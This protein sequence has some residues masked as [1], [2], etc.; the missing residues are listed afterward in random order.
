M[1]EIA[2]RRLVRAGWTMPAWRSAAGVWTRREAVLVAVE[3]DGA[4]G[5]GEAAPLPGM[6]REDVHACTR[7]IASAPT[8][9]PDELDRL[10]AVLDDAC[11][12]A[13]AWALF[14]AVLDARARA[15]GVSLASLLGRPAPRLAVAAVVDGTAA[16]L[17]ATTRGVRTLKLK[18]APTSG[19]VRATAEAVATIREAVGPGAAIRVD[20]NRSFA[21]AEVPALLEALTPLAIELV[22]EPALGLAPAL[23]LAT[24]PPIALDESLADPGAD[25]WIDH[26]VASGAVAALVLK[27]TILGPSRLLALAS[28]AT[29][30]GVATIVSHALEGPVGLAAAIEVALA[31]GGGAVGALASGLDSHG[32]VR[33]WGIAIP[34]LETAELVDVERTGTGLALD[35]VLARAEAFG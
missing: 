19:G 26:V 6:S 5:I 27:P 13:A 30:A 34:T 16:A 18:I 20:A 25:L 9:L 21:L 22:E 31:L 3:V 24:S 33:T 28:R 7:A 4:T 15:R 10:A 1:I 14:T 17:L 8:Q 35:G 29:R 23:R 32:G 11:P 12:P 2:S